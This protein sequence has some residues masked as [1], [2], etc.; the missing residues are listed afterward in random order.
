MFRIFSLVFLF[1]CLLL[2]PAAADELDQMLS[3]LIIGTWE[4]GNVPYGIVSFRQDGTYQ[5]KMFS[6]KDQTT[7]LL[8]L[9]GT[10][11]IVDSELQS[12]LTASN[13]L[14]APLG[15]GFTDKI[16]QINRTELVMI[17]A[18]GKRY[19]KYRVTPAADR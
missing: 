4:E 14:N 1:F 17:G 13:S 10:W 2:T 6:T 12:V 11:K 3:T 15:E 18:D 9:E 19:S 8:S 5:A 16:V 7:L